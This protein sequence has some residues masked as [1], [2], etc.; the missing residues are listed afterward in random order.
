MSH[1]ANKFQ[2]NKVSSVREQQDL[3]QQSI[4]EFIRSTGH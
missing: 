4:V 2:Q 3:S 1:Q